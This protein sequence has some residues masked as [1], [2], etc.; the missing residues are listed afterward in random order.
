LLFFHLLN[1]YILDREKKILRLNMQAFDA[2]WH[3]KYA[4]PSERKLFAGTLERGADV[5]C[6]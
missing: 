3:L 4:Y 6:H 2:E 1:I 5:F